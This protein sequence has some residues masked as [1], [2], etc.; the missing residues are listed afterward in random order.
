MPLGAPLGQHREAVADA[1]K[2][3]TV[4]K[5]SARRLYTAAQ[6]YARAATVAGGDVRKT[7][8]GAVSTVTKYQDRGTVLLRA[9]ISR[10][11]ADERAAFW[12]DVVQS[13]PDPAMSALR[14]RLRADETV[15]A[16]A[17]ERH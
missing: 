7:G 13:D 3:I 17:P 5:P 15:G 8:Q 6:I 16:T 4:G 14:R 12:R 2:A 1:E 9:A 11:P 10:L